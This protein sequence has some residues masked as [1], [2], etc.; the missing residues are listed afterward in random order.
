MVMGVGLILE[1]FSV[2][3]NRWVGWGTWDCENGFYI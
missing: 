2:R 3:H 1:Q